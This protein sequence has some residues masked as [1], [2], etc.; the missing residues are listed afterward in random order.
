MMREL[1]C[2]QSLSFKKCL[3]AFCFGHRFE[4]FLQ[5]DKTLD[6]TMEMM[7]SLAVGKHSVKF[8]CQNE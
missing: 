3:V 7:S 2:S 6:V 4:L 8:Q 1:K 5:A